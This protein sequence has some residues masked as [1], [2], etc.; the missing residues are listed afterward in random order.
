MKST[1]FLFLQIFH[2][3]SFLAV[4]AR[5]IIAFVTNL[6]IDNEVVTVYFLFENISTANVTVSCE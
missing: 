5:E 6:Y 4:T 3:L 2:N 1:H